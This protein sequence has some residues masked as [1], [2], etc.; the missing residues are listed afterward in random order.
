MS[1]FLAKVAI[2]GGASEYPIKLYGTCMEAWENQ[3]IQKYTQK[4]VRN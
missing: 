4:S 1:I 2:G 3:D